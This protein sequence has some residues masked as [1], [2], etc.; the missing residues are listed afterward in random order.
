MGGMERVRVEEVFES[1]YI[2]PCGAMV[3][4]FEGMLAERIGRPV[5]A[6]SSGTGALHLALRVL[7][8]RP[9]DEVGCSTLTFIA[10]VGPAVEMGATPVFVE[11][12]AESWCMDAE[13]LETAL[14]KHP[15]ARV[16]IAVD[17][18]GQ[19]A[20]YDAIAEVCARHGVALIVDA[21]EALGARYKG[22]PAGAA[23][24]A[25]F[26]S[27]NGNKIITTSGGGALA[28]EDWE[29]L[30]RAERL[31]QQAREKVA[32][33]EHRETG[34]NYRL[35]NVLAG[36]GA[37]Q[38]EMLE[39]YVAKRR[40]ICA[41][42]TEELAGVAEVMPE[43]NYGQSSRWLTVAR[44]PRRGAIEKGRPGELA[45]CVMAALEAANIESR[46]VWKPMHTQPVFAGC[47]C[48]GEPLSED[49][50]TDGLCLPSGTGMT[51]EDVAEVC[52]IA[53]EVA[54]A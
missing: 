2:A 40:E 48:Y 49:I 53:R 18:Y 10:S 8:L 26:F 34:Y 39:A 14:R 16:V 54:H 50:F 15:K 29:M 9:G 1:N 32:W 33:Y 31:S 41:W 11:C 7:G 5:L 42:Y 35:S 52:D 12:A 21:A 23:G 27:F 51:R 47:A 20:D 13:A 43:A 44:F 28:M 45:M 36:I 17:L 22:R 37:G 38:L 46:P 24:A 25:S 3:K 30:A 19:C 4:R 6:T